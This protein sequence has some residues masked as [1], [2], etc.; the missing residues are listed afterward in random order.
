MGGK[1]VADLW[2]ACQ[3]WQNDVP[4]SWDIMSRLSR[5]RDSPRR[6]EG[7]VCPQGS[8]VRVEERLVERRGA[9]KKRVLSDKGDEV[10]R[11]KAAVAAVAIA[12][13]WGDKC[14][15]L[16]GVAGG[17]SASRES[18]WGHL[19]KSLERGRKDSKD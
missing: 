19:E 7:E 8:G 13:K 12:K 15:L 3:E 10:E 4:S 18:M 16:K 14:L 6:K 5:R 17:Q 11:R 1:E 2:K 9:R